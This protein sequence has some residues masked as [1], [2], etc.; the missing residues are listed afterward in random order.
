KAKPMIIVMPN[1]RAQKD[2]K[3]Q[4]VPM[5]AAGAFA[6]FEGDLLNDLIPAIESRYGV[7][8]DRLDRA[9]AGLSMGGGQALNFGL[10]HLD[11]FAW[12]GGFSAA[13][14]TKMPAQLLPDP[15]KAATQ[16]KLI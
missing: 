3:R 4:K 14:N 15:E 6:N 9:I 11:R 10:G 16:I 8:S 13:P 7:S 5:Q 2:D 12:I 1:G